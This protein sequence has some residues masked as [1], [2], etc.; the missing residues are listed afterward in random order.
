MLTNSVDVVGNAIPIEINMEGSALQRQPAHSP[1]TVQMHSFNAL[2]N[3]S[4][5]NVRLQVGA[6][7]LGFA[8]SCSPRQLQGKK[9]N[10][11]GDTI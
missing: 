9:Q 5:H 7:V 4:N 3:M 1:S 6:S 10:E 2:F 8:T 11:G